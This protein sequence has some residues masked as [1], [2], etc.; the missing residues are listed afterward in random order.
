MAI[1]G[2]LLEVERLRAAR[3]VSQQ[4][5]RERDEADADEGCEE[6]PVEWGGRAVNERRSL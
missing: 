2:A 3:V 5:H 6:E 4:I 1:N